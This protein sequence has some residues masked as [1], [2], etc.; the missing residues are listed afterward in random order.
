[1]SQTMFEKLEL[2]DEKNL[3][4]Q[5]LPSTIE[6]QFAKLSFSK[7]LTPLLKTRKI[8]F[9]LVFAVNQKQLNDILCEVLP[10]LNANGKLWVAYPK[11][12]SKI[13][14]D[15]NR[16]CT[17][18]YL[19]ENGFQQSSEVVLDYCWSAIRFNR[20]AKVKSILD[21]EVPKKKKTRTAAA[22]A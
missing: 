20:A 17:W 19:C 8:D 14:S 21:A 2:K 12:T 9:A 10:A 6:K 13:A 22:L 18:G 4:I 11:S 3:L 15:L 1:M 5:G 16:D 7:N